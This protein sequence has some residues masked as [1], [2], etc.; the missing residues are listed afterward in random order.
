MAIRKYSRLHHVYWA[1]IYGS[2]FWR[3][4]V[5]RQGQNLERAFILYHLVILKKG[6]GR[7]EEEKEESNL[8]EKRTHSCYNKATFMIMF[9]VHR[10]RPHGIVTF[11]NRLHNL[12]L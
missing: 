9:I 8:R 6:G 2:S 12:G 3:I 1:E 7:E 10:N 4:G 5:N 11:H